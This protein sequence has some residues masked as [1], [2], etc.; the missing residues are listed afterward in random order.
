[1]LCLGQ[2]FPFERLLLWEEMQQKSKNKKRGGGSG[3][4]ALWLRG[5]VIY[6]KVSCV[7]TLDDEEESNKQIEIL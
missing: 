1:M 2:T 7:W 3:A 6:N 5:V 4:A